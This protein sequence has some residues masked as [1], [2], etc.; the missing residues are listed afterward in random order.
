MA[1][2]RQKNSATMTI[3]KMILFNLDK[4]LRVSKEVQDR[5]TSTT[6]V[7]ERK[8]ESAD[9]LTH[10]MQTIEVDEDQ[11]ELLVKLLT[12]H[13]QHGEIVNKVYECLLNLLEA[14]KSSSQ[15]YANIGVIDASKGLLQ[16]CIK[17]SS[18]Y[19]CE[20]AFNFLR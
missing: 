18:I 8:K 20:M 16:I 14:S 11:L 2:K 15:A 4:L 17:H 9:V 1:K 5:Y 12:Q 6:S 3:I 7:A 13:E 10:K 19:Q